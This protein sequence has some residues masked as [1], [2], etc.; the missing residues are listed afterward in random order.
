MHKL[1]DYPF[2]IRPMTP[3]EGIGYLIN[4][5]DFNECFSDG[6]TVADAIENG[7]DALKTAIFALEEL[8]FPVPAP[9]SGGL[10]GKFVTRVPKT[11]HAKLT[12]RARREG[13]SL[14]ALV[15]TL[16]AEGIG[17]R[18]TDVHA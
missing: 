13:V 18:S 16:L 7:M 10:S 17:M 3:D 8:G 14:N 4:F 9:M 12:I 15:T 5:P 11:L 6:E 1:E 2:E